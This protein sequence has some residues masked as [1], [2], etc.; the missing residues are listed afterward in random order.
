MAL[1]C[2]ELRNRARTAAWTAAFGALRS[3]SLLHLGDLPGAEYE[4]AEAAG[5][6]TD[7][8]AAVGSWAIALLTEA[9]IEQG[10]HEEAATRLGEPAANPD[11]SGLPP[12]RARGRLLLALDRPD[13]ALAAFTRVALLVR[14]H[15]TQLLPYLP[16]R[17]DLAQALLRLGQRDQAHALLMEELASPAPGPRE[18]GIALRVLSATEEPERRLPTLSRA[19]TELRRS[20]ERIEL[21]RVLDDFARTLDTLGEPSTAEVFRRRAAGL[22]AA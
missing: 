13:E 16:W 11:L 8:P 9:L 18:R 4:A 10:R 17:S 14:R 3:E 12:L 20:D 22:L 21:A 6:G 7:Q 15:T 2:V 1:W 5:D 19:A